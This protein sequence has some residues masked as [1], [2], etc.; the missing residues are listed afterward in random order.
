MW[1]GSGGAR[2]DLD[3]P[4]WQRT[5]IMESGL[6]RTMTC[7]WTASVDGHRF[8]EADV[9]GGHE[10][11][12]FYSNIAYW[13]FAL[14]GLSIYLGRA[15]GAVR[16]TDYHL[17]LWTTLV[18]IGVCSAANHDE[19]T[20]QQGW[21]AMDLN[22][23]ALLVLAIVVPRLCSG[24]PVDDGRGLVAAVLQAILAGG[25]LTVFTL[26]SLPPTPPERHKLDAADMVF[27]V[28]IGV[29]LLVLLRAVRPDGPWYHVGWILAWDGLTV[30]QRL[31]RKAILWL[32]VGGTFWFVIESNCGV[33]DRGWAA[34]GHIVWHVTTAYAG[35]TLITLVMALDRR[36]ARLE[37]WWGACAAHGWAV[38]IWPQYLATD[39]DGVERRRPDARRA[40]RAGGLIL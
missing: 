19:G 36:E 24:E 8:C 34:S 9:S 39:F 30:P 13:A 1:G 32:A 5:Y 17:F 38:W 10:D 22:A 28:L 7:L 16:P 33:I 37:P 25:I 27:M 6:A 12:N 40:P 14:L 15:R 35:F 3:A 21:S 23:M 2:A 4:S 29:L 31:L 18:W 20:R 26:N 11:G